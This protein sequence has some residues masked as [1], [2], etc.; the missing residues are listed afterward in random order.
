[1]N[2]I[3]RLHQ[4]VIAALHGPCIGMAFELALA[5]DIRVATEDCVLGLP[6]IAFGLSP[7]SGARRA[8]CARSASRARASSC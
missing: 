1:M 5:A 7:T 2:R 4:P 8:S 3:A 6:E